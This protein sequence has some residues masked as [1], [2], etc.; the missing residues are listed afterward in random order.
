[1]YERLKREG[2]YL[3]IFRHDSSGGDLFS[4]D[5]EA[6]SV[7]TDPDIEAKFSA[8][9]GLEEFRREDGKFQFKLHYPNEN[10]TNI[11][12]QSNNFASE[13]TDQ[14]LING[15]LAGG[16]DVVERTT[17]SGV[18]QIIE[19]ENPG[20]SD[21]VLEQNNITTGGN[22]YTLSVPNSRFKPNTTYTIS[23]W[24]AY[25]DQSFDADDGWVFHSRIWDGDD[26]PVQTEGQGQVFES[27]GNDI[28][29]DGI[30]WQRRYIRITTP[31]TLSTTED[32]QWYLGYT[33]TAAT[34]PT[35]GTRRWVTNMIISSAP[36][37]KNYP[38]DYATF[39]GGVRGYEA[40]S[41][42]STASGW[43]G[44][45]FDTG[46][47][48]LADGSVNTAAWWWAIGAHTFNG[49]SPWIPGPGVNTKLVELWV[50]APMSMI[51]GDYELESRLFKEGSNNLLNLQI[52][53]VANGS[54]NLAFTTANGNNAF[55][56]EP[57]V[58]S[59]MFFAIVN[60]MGMITYA[61]SY[62][63][64]QSAER[65]NFINKLNAIADDEAFILV[66]NG[67]VYSDSAVDAAM[68][69]FNPVEWRG[70]D[71]FSK[72]SYSYCAFGHGALGIV[73]D[74][75]T[76]DDPLDGDSEINIT[77]NS[78][79]DIG[80][81]GYGTAIVETT[82]TSDLDNTRIPLDVKDGQ[83]LLYKVRMCVSQAQKDAGATWATL[84]F[85]NGGN[86]EISREVITVD[87]VELMQTYEIFASVPTGTT[88]CAVWTNGTQAY[89][90]YAQLYRA[91]FSVPVGNTLKTS[92]NGVA[93]ANL[94][95]SPIAG[96]AVDDVSW[97]SAYDSDSNLYNAIDM[98][99]FEADNVNW[100]TH[101]LTG[102]EKS[103]TNVSGTQSMIELDGITIDPSRPYFVSM[104]VNASSK[105]AG[106][107]QFSS[108]VKDASG[109]YDTLV[110]S[111]GAATTTYITQDSL[112][113]AASYTNQW[114]L[115]SN[116]IL[117]HHWTNEQH[118]AFEA[119]FDE[120]F[121][122]VNFEDSERLTKGVGVANN[123]TGMYRWRSDSKT[124]NLR[125]RDEGS[126]S[127]SKT[128]WA[129]PIVSEVLVA[130][131]FEDKLTAIDFVLK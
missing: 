54:P 112:N 91:G 101:V 71:Y 117:P 69:Q 38:G 5:A 3:L 42:E 110:T 73:T 100:G 15:N 11:W 66:S 124:L 7:G 74:R 44:L 83:F 90:E 95:N 17:S 2:D 43:G 63:L 79:D 65:S 86:V 19:K 33:S 13:Q 20:S 49:G 78:I 121:G 10:I 28:I 61:N 118:Q 27:S 126:I 24:V 40:I 14:I 120:Y 72:Y 50:Y 16:L 18:W 102:T 103:V 1:M 128:S 92:S 25:E 47:Y 41:I 89:F 88:Q 76:F 32:F 68:A 21:F 60:N 113:S 30:R 23:A 31:N 85:Y 8:L 51:V 29:L 109:V 58:N 108:R 75:C 94:I 84:I 116:F 36:L 4:S 123:S 62:Q 67:S 129:L 35:F 22:Q 125:F 106:S 115:L 77:F 122:A 46:H 87:S 12:K 57:K 48:T 119:K 105:D 107:L 97:K 114:V 70:T 26:N 9:N 45:E 59:D 37:I 98:P 80:S 104:W 53:G 6:R 111:T 34:V 96:N 127:S 93:V 81:N 39:S 56:P 64:T 99:Q 55:T 130:S 131:M 52:R 82:Q